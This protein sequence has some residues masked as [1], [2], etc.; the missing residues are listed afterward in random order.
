[1]IKA[2]APRTVLIIILAIAW[3]ELGISGRFGHLWALA[4]GPNE[5]ATEKLLPHGTTGS[6]TAA[7]GT[8]TV[9]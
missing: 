9:R 2:G 4:F 1:M 7:G 3:L 8:R 6:D 5:V